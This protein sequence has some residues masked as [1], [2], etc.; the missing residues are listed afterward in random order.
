M[1]LDLGLPIPLGGGQPKPVG[2]GVGRRLGKL[3]FPRSITISVMVVT[4][5]GLPL[6]LW[7][8]IGLEAGLVP[9]WKRVYL[10]FNCY[11]Y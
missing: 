10:C 6:F 3:I 4:V 9:S 7:G 5:Q 11:Y 1:E 8:R 2:R